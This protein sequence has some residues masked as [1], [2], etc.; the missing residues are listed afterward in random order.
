[1]NNYRK[2]QRHGDMERGGTKGKSD[3]RVT[4]SKK[5]QM[6]ALLCAQAWQRKDGGINLRNQAT[7]ERSGT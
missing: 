6:N 5:R 1:M 7:R 3:K 4:E 2:H